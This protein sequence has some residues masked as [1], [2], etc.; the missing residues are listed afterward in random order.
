MFFFLSQR[1]ITRGTQETST[2]MSSNTCI[3]FKMAVNVGGFLLKFQSILF[4]VIEDNS[5]MTFDDVTKFKLLGNK[6]KLLIEGGCT[7][8]NK[9]KKNCFDKI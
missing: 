6:V 3:K 9:V 8:D 1:Q 2:T 4:V 5:E 7:E